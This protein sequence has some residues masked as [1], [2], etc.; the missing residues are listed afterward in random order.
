MKL[1]L[2]IIISISCIIVG[3]KPF[4]ANETCNLHRV[5]EFKPVTS[6]TYKIIRTANEQIEIDEVAQDTFRFHLTWKDSCSYILML[7]S[8]T[9]N[10]LELK[11]D[12][13]MLV[14]IIEANATSYKCNVTQKN[15]LTV[16]EVEKISD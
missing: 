10:N 4:V 1:K 12:D 16:M 13:R 8:T 7:E 2:L 11:K 15:E 5:G 14:E 9:N 3:C 6:S